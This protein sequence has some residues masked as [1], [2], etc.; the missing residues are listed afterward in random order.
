MAFA[1]SITPASLRAIQNTPL[2]KGV[3]SNSA[4][5]TK[6]EVKE[7]Y[8]YLREDLQNCATIEFEE[9]LE[10]IFGYK[11]D[12]NVAAIAKKIADKEEFKK[13]MEKYCEVVAHETGRYVPFVE[14]VN[15]VFHQIGPGTVQL[16]RN[17]P[18]LL[19]GSYASRKPDV[20]GVLQ[21]VFDQG[22]RSDP[23]NLSQK[24]PGETN[25]FHW[26]EAL[27]FWEFKLEFQSHTL[28]MKSTS[29]SKLSSST[30]RSILNCWNRIDR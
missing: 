28:Y 26:G 17:D 6:T 30:R 19:W 23:D 27:D 11:Y 13:L 22:D 1:R 2:S 29:S 3:S 12:S 4:F 14:M 20:L 15:Y 8:P 18:T 25:A 5:D 21:G 9:Y 24:G 7:Y 10:F 16:C